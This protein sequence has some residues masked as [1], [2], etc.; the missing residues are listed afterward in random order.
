M[1]LGDNGSTLAL[2]S[3]VVRGFSDVGHAI[4]LEGARDMN[5]SG[6]VAGSAALIGFGAD[7]ETG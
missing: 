4:S 5:S 6:S 1:V 7:E 2:K 3:T